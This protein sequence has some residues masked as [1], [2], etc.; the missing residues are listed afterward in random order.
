LSRYLL[1]YPSLAKGRGRKF[2]RGRSPL[3]LILPSPANINS[4]LGK[5]SQLERGRGE[6]KKNHSQI[7]TLISPLYT[8]D[9]I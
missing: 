3:S 2:E 6:V 7:D 5:C 8:M 4:G 9:G 1:T